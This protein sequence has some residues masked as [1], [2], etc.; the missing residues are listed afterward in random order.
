MKTVW[1]KGLDDEK[2]MHVRAEYASS[3]VFRSRLI[4]ILE[5]KYKITLRLERSKEDLDNPNWA[6][7]QAY[8]MGFEK[9][10]EEILNILK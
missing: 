1:T 9:G 5:D 3:P 2:A 10:I 7:K 6:I 8:Q 4:E